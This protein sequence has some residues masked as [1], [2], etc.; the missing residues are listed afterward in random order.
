LVHERLVRVYCLIWH[1][2]YLVD[3]LIDTFFYTY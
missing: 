2:S 3:M 1:I